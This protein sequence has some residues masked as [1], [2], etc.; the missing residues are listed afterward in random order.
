LDTNYHKMSDFRL[1]QKYNVPAPRYTSYPTMPYWN[2]ETFKSAYWQQSVKTTFNQYNDSCGIS[3]YIHLPFC[4]DLCTYCGCN[5]RIT[6][7]HQVELPYIAALLHEWEMYRGLMVNTPVIKAIHLGGSTPTFFEAENLKLLINGLLTGSIIHSDA[8]FSFEAHPGNTSIKH[9]QTVYDLGFRR[10]SLGIQDFDP[11]VQLIINRKQSFEQVRLVT[12][13]ARSIGFTS[14]N[15]DL[16]YGLPLQTLAGLLKTMALVNE[17]Q[18]D[19]IAFY[20]YAHIP[21]IKPGQRQFT[22][23]DLPGPE[24]K[25]LLALSGEQ[26]LLNYG[27]QKIGM[28]HFVLS[29]DSML[30]AKESGSLYRNFMGYTDHQTALLIGLGASAISDSGTVFAQNV[31]GVEEYIHL[32]NAGNFPL[33]KGHILTSDDQIIRRNI[34]D[35]MCNGYTVWNHHTSSIDGYR[36]MYNRLELLVHDGLIMMDELGLVVTPLGE[37]FLRTICMALDLRFWANQPEASVFSMAV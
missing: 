9:L 32:V 16:I 11:R 4:E 25:N 10:L 31:K 33:L 27:Y 28:D 7:N 8:D 36:S 24:L 6:K 17:L 12:M 22:T 30:E 1:I 26:A 18:P 35:I 23:D 5:T 3:I 29:S 15:Y 14:I 37:H 2:P 21:W 20:S 34:L 19:R 13:Q